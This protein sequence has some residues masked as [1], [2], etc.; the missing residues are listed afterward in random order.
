MR[1]TKQ[2]L[3]L[4]FILLFPVLC[5]CWNY[6]EIDQLLIV[7]GVALDKGA[8][9]QYEM[10]V[11]TVNISGGKE[12]K[13]KSEIFSAEGRTL[14]EAARNIIL[15][16]GKRPYWS[17]TKVI[18]MSRKIAEEGIMKVLDWYKRDTETR[19]DV[20]I[21]ISKEDTAKQILETENS[22]EDQ[23]VSYT[24][25]DI[26][27]NEK[28]VG[29]TPYN[30]ILLFN[31]EQQ[32]KGASSILAAV[33]MKKDSKEAPEIKGCAV[34]KGDKLKSF[35]D[36]EETL[37]L[38][39]IRDELKAAILPVDLQIDNEKVKVALEIFQNKTD[40]KPVSENEKVKYEIKVKTTAALAEE[41]GDGSSID[42]EG[43]KELEKIT[44]S[45]LKEKLE[46]LIKKMQSEDGADI[47][48][49]AAKLNEENPKMYQK[50]NSDWETVF[51]ELEV[52]VEAEVVI[53]NTA[54]LAGPAEGSK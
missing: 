11:E 2:L 28:S 6:R 16:S 21:L 29:R 1:K 52:K 9:E 39:F 47:F 17:H 8:D 41:I 19:E 35:L 36:A 22:G 14:F 23:I 15:I 32:T 53:K 10:T 7:A 12:S 4:C 37:Y 38:L 45:L 48:K 30:S 5:G 33:G 27:E 43:I 49:F 31:I 42:E 34:I 51:K 18:I 26:L 20:H 25:D 40:I 50:V 24:L 44:E 3:I 13:M 54:T 46:S